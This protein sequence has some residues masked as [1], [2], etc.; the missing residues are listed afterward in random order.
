MHRVT[1][2]F[3]EEVFIATEAIDEVFAERF[4]HHPYMQPANKQASAVPDPT[5]ATVPLRGVWMERATH[6]R[7]THLRE[8]NAYDP[9]EARRPGTIGNLPTVEFA[10]STYSCFVD[11]QVRD[12]DQIER[13]A[14]RTM[15]RAKAATVTPNGTVSV[16]MNYLGPVA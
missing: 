13:L 14:T 10:F 15:Y 9:H 8:P 3:D 1:P 12:G 4:I 2:Q 7:A 5:R 11:F 16:P 6:L